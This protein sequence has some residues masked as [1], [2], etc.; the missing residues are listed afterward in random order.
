M[1]NYIYNTRLIYKICLV[2]LI[3]F[4]ASCEKDD[5]LISTKAELLSY[6]PAGVKHGEDIRFIGRNLNKV[7]DI[8]FNGAT[9]SKAEFKQQ[10]DELIILTVPANAE[11][12]VV[13]L[14]TPEGDI[15][16]K[17]PIDFNVPFTV[18]S[19]A[20]TAR[21]GG[22]L[23]IKGEFVNWISAVEFS[24]GVTDTNFVSKSLNEIVVQVPMEAQTGKL[25][26]WGAGTEPIN[27]ES[28][29]ELTVIL[30]SITTITTTPIRPEGNLTITGA[31][32]DLVKGV[33]IAGVA[34]PLTN[35]ESRSTTQIVVK[36][37]KAAR[38]GKISLQAHSDVLVESATEMSVLLP[39]ITSV[40]P[41]PI[42]KGSNMTIIGTNLDLVTGIMFKGLDTPVKEFVSRS[43]TQIVVKFPL[44]AN[45]GVIGLTT[46]SD[47]TVESAMPVAIVG[48]LPPLPPLSYVFYDDN[49]QNNWQNWGW[50]N[51][52]DP[53][54]ADFVRDGDKS[55]KVNF[56][57]SWGGVKFANSEVSTAGYTELTFAIY[58]GAGTEGK[59]LNV[60]PNGG[61]MYAAVIQEGKWVE[62]KVKLTDIGNPAKIIDLMMQETGWAGIIYIDH[63]GLR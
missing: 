18:S 63:V 20:A 45:K 31:D 32:L 54:N 28:E 8:A 6:G 10:S 23:S 49:Y 51:E 35:F 46:V 15:V 44:T 26:F 55:L 43:L 39:A 5:D 19:F 30:P 3:V 42:D 40:S 60:Q 33:K 37:P 29:T 11:R 48:D 38:A 9:V 50:G 16:S 2:F 41:N 52:N 13:T 58:G 7:T 27:V 21:P 57:N 22:T 25:I 12:G 24:N 1:K 53:E 14:K 34:S 36:L 17:A 62:Y 59:T 47:V 61:A 56:A 4:A